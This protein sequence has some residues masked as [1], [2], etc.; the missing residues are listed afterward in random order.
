M[1]ATADDRMV[2]RM[3][4]YFL[5]GLGGGL[6]AIGRHLAGL[7]AARAF[8]PEFPWGTFSVNA[9]GGL[10]MGVLVGALARFEPAHEQEL[11]LLLGV[12]FLGGFTT[13]SAFSLET[14]RLIE[15]GD[16]ARG[17]IYA[18][19]SVVVSIGAVFLGLAVVRSFP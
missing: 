1:A 5:I 12:G 3:L 6:G 17:A 8:G 10:A 7:A 13:F 16:L 2:L 18:V 14:A 15:T 4:H 19:A 9:I 11:R